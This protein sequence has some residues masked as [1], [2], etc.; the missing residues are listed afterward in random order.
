MNK[1]IYV[2]ILVLLSGCAHYSK[3]TNTFYG[4]GKYKDKEEE[5]ES[6]PPLKDI[7]NFSV[8]KGD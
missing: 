1:Y 3:E 7:V 8:L 2:I 6:Y 4:W 5:F